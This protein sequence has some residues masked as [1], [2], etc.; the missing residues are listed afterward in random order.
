MS[1]LLSSEQSEYVGKKQDF[2][3]FEIKICLAL[4]KK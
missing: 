1:C 2:Y 4:P 3:R